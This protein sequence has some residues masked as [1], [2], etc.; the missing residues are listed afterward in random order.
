MNS[1]FSLIT[2]IPPHDTSEGELALWY[3][4]SVI[5]ASCWVDLG[6]AASGNRRGTIVGTF[7]SKG[8]GHTRWLDVTTL[9]SNFIGAFIVATTKTCRSCPLIT[10]GHSNLLIQTTTTASKRW[11]TKVRACYS[12]QAFN[13][14]SIPWENLLSFILRR[15]PECA[16]AC[17]P[18]PTNP[19]DLSCARDL[20][21][22]RCQ[23]NSFFLDE[24]KSRTKRRVWREGRR[25]NEDISFVAL[26]LLICYKGQ[27]RRFC[28][29]NL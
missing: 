1:N 9:A 13:T 18:A 11:E 28:A 17:S 14:I 26:D 29:V 19:E 15:R 4:R 12:S 25:K 20:G 21:P 2:L 5:V 27:G 22:K 16:V 23:L 10:F 8:T 3:S 24:K 6:G 7:V